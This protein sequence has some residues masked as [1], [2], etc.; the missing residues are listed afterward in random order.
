M[1]YCSRFTCKCVDERDSTVPDFLECTTCHVRIHSYAYFND[2]PSIFFYHYIFVYREDLFTYIHQFISD[3]GK[4][5]C[6]IFHPQNKRQK[7]T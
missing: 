6:F 1:C 7:S 5:H 4:L 2:W 3:L